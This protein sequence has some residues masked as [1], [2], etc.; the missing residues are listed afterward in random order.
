MRR[1]PTREGFTLI[2][3]LIVIVIVGILA[4]IAIRVFW[5][6]KDRGMESTLKSDLRTV[7]VH[8]ET[9]Y[10]RNYSYADAV[11]SLVSFSTSPSV[12]VDIQYADSDGWAAVASSPSLMGTRCGLWIGAVPSGLDSPAT[13]PGRVQCGP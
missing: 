9:W 11:D 5:T 12:D 10:E 4:T 13:M 6:A 8:Q 3:L 1:L 7:A 2:E